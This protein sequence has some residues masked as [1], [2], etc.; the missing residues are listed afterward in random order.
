V[1]VQGQRSKV[2]LTAWLCNNSP[3]YP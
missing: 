1:K 2:K 3:N